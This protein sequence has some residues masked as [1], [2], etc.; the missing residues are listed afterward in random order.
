[1]SVIN[2]MLRDL[3]ARRAAPA[4]PAGEGPA[5]MRRGT[6]S[7]KGRGQNGARAG[8]QS[9][10]MTVAMVAVLVAAAMG[11]WYWHDSSTPVAVPVQ[12]A[13]VTKPAPVAASAPKPASS[14]SAP[15]PFTALPVQIAPAAGAQQMNQM[16]DQ[17]AKTAPGDAPAGASPAPGVPQAGQPVLPGMPPGVTPEMMQQLAKTANVGQINVPSLPPG[18]AYEL[19]QQLSQAAPSAGSA[20][21][22]APV[23]PVTPSAAATSP[24]TAPAPSR[25]AMAGSTQAP[26]FS[27]PNPVLRPL[28]GSETVPPASSAAPAPAPLAVEPAVRSPVEREAIPKAA[29]ASTRATTIPQPKPAKAPP[30]PRQ[31]AALETLTQARN[32]WNAGSR[33][34][35]LDLMRKAVA[36][37]ERAHAG[38]IEPGGRPSFQTLVRELARMELAEG[39]V[40]QVLEL[41][42]RLEPL[43]DDQ[44]DLWAVRG[45]AAQRLGQHQE[46]VNAYGMALKLRPGEARWMLASAVSLA[47]QGQLTAAAEQAEKARAAGA[48]S[49]EVLT[50][51]RQLGVPLR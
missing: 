45:N 41:L 14:A 5:G 28:P 24:R 10:R 37:A 43:L 34:A 4:L 38:G 3:D 15:V 49:P 50:Y 33:E 26:L 6:A 19:K 25:Q 48:V 17:A 22:R 21:A 39:Q 13:Q 44:A 35:A 16:L 36:V 30:D 40:S 7:V 23:Q 31:A 8:T 51:L 29:T 32:L 9:W 27:R 20:T 12:V 11:W 46:S 47:V 1:M 18:L 2:K 42:V